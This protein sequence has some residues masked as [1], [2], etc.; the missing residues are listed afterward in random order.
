MKRYIFL[1]VLIGILFSA[2]YKDIDIYDKESYKPKLGISSIIT[3]D[4]VVIAWIYKTALPGDFGKDNFLDNATVKLYE[5][6]SLVD[7]MQYVLL[8]TYG[9]Y[10]SSYLP[11]A[12][13][14]YKIEVE[15]DGQV[16]W[17][18]D[19]IPKK[20]AFQ[21]KKLLVK[22]SSW[23]IYDN[24]STHK[25]LFINGI[26]TL[27]LTNTSDYYYAFAG[28]SYMDSMKNWFGFSYD[29]DNGF[30]SSNKM[31]MS[32]TLPIQES[33]KAMMYTPSFY[34]SGDLDVS[35]DFSAIADVQNSSVTLYFAVVH[36]SKN[37]YEFYKSWNIYYSTSNN[38]FV[39]PVN[40]RVNVHNGLGLLAGYS[41]SV[42]SV[43]INF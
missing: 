16:A 27:T 30:Q 43:K 41:I 34:Q 19:S 7:N 31:F 13:H 12:G 35:L 42:D 17:A 36:L 23:V 26:A 25:Y 22:D 10:Q 15:A 5:D 4:S 32:I 20:P 14:K 28:Y 8:G 2:C 1:F 3:A 6:D 9:Y 29:S 18:E 33:V 39:E 24:D 11:Q 40:I 37:L 21:I 38:P